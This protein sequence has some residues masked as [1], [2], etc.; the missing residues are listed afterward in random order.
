MEY[1]SISETGS[2]EHNED[3]IGVFSNDTITCF[4]VA[5]GLGGHGKGEVASEIAV[6]TAKDLIDQNCN[7]N[8]FFDNYF[9][10]CE[11]RLVNE[12]DDQ[13]L[14]D[15]IKTTLVMAVMVE[16]SLHIAHVGDSRAYFFRSNKIFTRTLDHSVPQ[17]LVAAGELKEKKIRNHPDRNRLLKVMGERALFSDNKKI[18]DDQTIDGIQPGD[19]I[20]L[21]SDGFWELIN[22]REMCKT[23]KK[24]ANVTDWGTTMK[25]IVEKHG[26]GKD[27]DNYSA[28]CVII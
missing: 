20:L 16:N 18:Y 1:F 11:E 10:S 5:D 25:A 12:R 23:L 8:S 17:I 7:E 21:C 14:P 19:A 9:D 13:G 24:S 22:E 26:N 3:S 4:I 15:S 6:N 28:V 2:R 27:M